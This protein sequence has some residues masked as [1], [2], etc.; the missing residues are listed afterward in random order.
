[1]FTIHE[2]VKK[3]VLECLIETAKI[4]LRGKA[5]KFKYIL[6][7]GSSMIVDIDGDEFAESDYGL[8]VE[9]SMG[10]Q[11]LNQ[12]ID[13]L[14]QMAI[15]NQAIDFS[16]VMKLYTSASMSE[17]IRMIENNEAMLKQ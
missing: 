17:K 7:D 10:L 6:S 1:V 3:R 12:K 14:A 15:Q 11:E 2:D 5:K 16:T 8:V 9:N 13:G 4:A